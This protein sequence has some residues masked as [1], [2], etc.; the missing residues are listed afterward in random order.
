MAHSPTVSGRHRHRLLR[1]LLVVDRSEGDATDEAPVL[2]H[3]CNAYP[4][5]SS[6]YQFNLPIHART[7]M[8]IRLAIDFRETGSNSINWLRIAESNDESL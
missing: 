8:P 7:A 6:L 5:T 1:L 2:G 3:Y 4:M